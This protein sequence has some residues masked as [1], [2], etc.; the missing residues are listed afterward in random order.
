MMDQTILVTGAAGFIGFHVARQ[1]LAEGRPVIG[2][3]NL[4]SYYDPALKQA[5]L[6]L[7]RSDSRFS[8]V[9][10]DLA[11][12]ETIAA[13]FGQHGFAKVVHLAAQAGVRYSIE[14]PQAYA[15]SNLQGFLNVLEGC[16]NNRC[17]HLV[18]ASSS[19]VY[20]A[21]TKLP[22]AVQ[23]RTDH[24]VSF[25]AATKKANEVMAQAYSH[26]YRLPVTA[27]RFFTI[28]GPW[29]RPDMAMFLFVNAIMA[30]TP[31]RLFNHGRMRRDFTYIDDVTRV[32]SKLIDRV[33]ADDPAAANAPSKVYN[34]GNHRPEELMHVVGLLEQ[35]LGRTAIK[36]LLPMQPGDVLE[37]FA[38][39]EDLMRDTGFAPSTPIEHGV[40]NFVTWYRDYFKV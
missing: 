37:T 28:Y 16:R 14:H 35:E 9:K 40:R 1:L 24:P 6:E 39:V 19:S 22:F 10:A 33:P 13:L 36:E 26:L 5:R 32:V 8:F 4:N 12:R 34:V 2:L 7:L 11:D 15:D 17:R 30:G 29:G 27:L 3:D 23:D 25:Y 20:G 18:Y 38:D 21:N 31:I